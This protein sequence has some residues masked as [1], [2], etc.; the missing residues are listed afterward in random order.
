MRRVFILL[1]IALLL[2][3]CNGRFGMDNT[4]S[5][6]GYWGFDWTRCEPPSPA[7][8]GGNEGNI[9]NETTRGGGVNVGTPATPDTR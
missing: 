2:A 5:G 1:A 7:P 4:S 8:I 3:G 6:G 9:P